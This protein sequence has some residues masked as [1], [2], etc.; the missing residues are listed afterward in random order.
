MIIDQSKLIDPYPAEEDET[1][2]TTNKKTVMEGTMKIMIFLTMRMTIM[3][4]IITMIM[5]IIEMKMMIMML[6]NW[7]ISAIIKNLL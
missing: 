5:K 2:E 3:K 1:K 6:M 7:K 4:T